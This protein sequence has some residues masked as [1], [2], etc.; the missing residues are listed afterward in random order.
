MCPV[1]TDEP[2]DPAIFVDHQGQ[3]VY[4]CCNTCRRQFTQ[5]PH[6]YAESLAQVMAPAQ[7]VANGSDHDDH[8]H[9]DEAV[10]PSSSDHDHGDHH[11]GTVSVVG[12]TIR[13]AGRFHPMVVHFPIG[14]LV[15]ALLAE[16]LRM[17]TGRPW[18]GGAA[19][20]CV[21]LGAAGAVAAAALGWA[22]AAFAGYAGDMAATLLTHRWLGTSVALWAVT[23]AGISEAAIRSGGDG[24]QR[25]YRAMLVVGAVL[26][27]LTGHFGGVLV[28]GASYYL[29]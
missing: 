3:R 5:D 17:V 24:W 16:I 8:G 2:I 27:G 11:E 23:T 13:W 22:H 26:V 18:L 28:Y 9:G 1:L 6:R 15:A 19:R 7:T 25:L 21:L 14:L 20:F 29:W 4:F 10:A 12:R